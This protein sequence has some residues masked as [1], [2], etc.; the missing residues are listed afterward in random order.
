MD[1]SSIP[2]SA[3]VADL[4]TTMVDAMA[5]RRGLALTDEQRRAA[6]VLDA[7]LA[8]RQAWLRAVPLSFLEPVEPG[9][10]L[11][12]IERGGRSASPGGVA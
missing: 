4:T 5:A 6:A 3:A 7:W 11:R 10:A 1:S 2:T 12:W 9:T 8:P